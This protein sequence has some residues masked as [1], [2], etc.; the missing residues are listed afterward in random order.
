[1]VSSAMRWVQTHRARLQHI[2]PPAPCVFNRHAPYQQRS[3]SKP[4]GTEAAK[5][6][7]VSVI[8]AQD[9]PWQPAY[10][11]SDANLLSDW[12]FMGRIVSVASRLE[13]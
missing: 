11:T 5:R 1:M 13:R 7:V 12:L 4:Q 6:A 2:V 8:N 3:W 9:K 10:S